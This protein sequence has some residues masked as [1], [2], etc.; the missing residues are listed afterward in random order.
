M[1]ESTTSTPLPPMRESGVHA[2]PLLL[3]AAVAPVVCSALLLPV[4]SI[5]PHQLGLIL[6]AIGVATLLV[7]KQYVAKLSGSPDYERSKWVDHS[8]V[9]AFVV[10]LCLVVA[11]AYPWA[12]EIATE[13]CACL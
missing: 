3:G 4:D 1:T 12:T 8:L 9:V 11:H 2:N 6:A 5:G 13:A 7:F 10:A